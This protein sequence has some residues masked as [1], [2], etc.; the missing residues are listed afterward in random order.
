MEDNLL[1]R[2]LVGKVNALE[3]RLRSALV[4]VSNII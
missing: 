1:L 3:L 4:C 2:D